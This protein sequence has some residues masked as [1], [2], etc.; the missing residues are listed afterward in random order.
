MKGVI[1]VGGEGTRLRPLTS[2]LPKPMAPIANEP[3]L[4]R[5]IEWIKSY[6]ITDIV[7]AMCYLP[8]RIREQLGDGSS[9]GVSLTYVVEDSP[10]GTAGA[11]KNAAGHIDDTCFVF[12]GDIL[13]DL[14]L[15]AMLENHKKVGARVSISLTEVE[16]PS[17]FGVVEM[18]RN[19]RIERFTE[20]PKRE[21]ARS[22]WINAGTYI[23]N[24]DVLDLVPE[25]EFWMFERNLFPD[26]LSE[27]SLLQGYQSSSYWLDLGTPAKYRE[28]HTDILTGRCK[29][30]LNGWVRFGLWID[31]T[32][33]VDPGARVVGPAIIGANSVIEHDVVLGPDT[34]VGAN[35]VIKNGSKVQHSILWD[36]AQVNGGE[37]VGSVLADGVH[38]NGAIVHNAILGSCVQVGPGNTLSNGIRIFPGHR[39]PESTILC[40]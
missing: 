34:I 38:V 10:L 27:G 35:C 28:A 33:K 22:N 39:I 21:D 29:V 9:L 40:E 23:V 24:P 11:V 15:G 12:N 7:L 18:D 32:A 20:K 14:D 31:P 17:Q 8:D 6:G 25:N 19:G 30:A 16:D 3:F 26:L 2:R 37:I 36:G 1:L 13:T 5:M 4:V